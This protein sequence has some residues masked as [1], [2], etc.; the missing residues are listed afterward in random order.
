MGDFTTAPDKSASV[1]V[2]FGFSADADGKWR[3]YGSLSGFQNT[4]LDYFIFL[5]DTLYETVTDRSPAAADPLTDP[6]QAQADYQRKYRENLEPVN[7]GG[8]TGNQVLYSSQGSYILLDN[9]ELGN[10]QFINGGAPAGTPVGKGFDGTNPLYDVNTTGAYLNKTSGFQ[11]L[12]QAYDNYQPIRETTISAPNDP[13]TNGTQKLYYSQ[14]WGA[15]SVFINVD[16]RSYRDI[17]LKNADGTDD[18]GRE[19]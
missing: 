9:H 2:K 19:S 8:F 15:N 11:A 6:A 18:D 1:A 12:L 3:P 10:K 5:G 7:V 16:D 14:Q 17:R 13:R 4:D